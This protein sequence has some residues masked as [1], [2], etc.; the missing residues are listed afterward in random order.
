MLKRKRAKTEVGILIGNLL[1]TRSTANDGIAQK[2]LE[3]YHFD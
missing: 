1:V 2:F 3:K